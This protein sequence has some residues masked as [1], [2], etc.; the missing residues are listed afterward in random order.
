MVDHLLNGTGNNAPALLNTLRSLLFVEAKG[1]ALLLPDLMGEYVSAI[2]YGLGDDGRRD[3]EDMQAL[4]RLW[5]PQLLV[6][7]E[8]IYQL[9]FNFPDAT[10]PFRHVKL[11][12]GVPENS[13][14]NLVQ[15]CN[16]SQYSN[17]CI[18]KLEF[19]SS[20]LDADWSADESLIAVCSAKALFVVDVVL[21]S[22]LL[23]WEYP[24]RLQN[25][26]VRWSPSDTA[27]AM[28]DGQNMFVVFL[29]KARKEV[30]ATEIYENICR[31]YGVPAFEW[32][33]NQSIVYYDITTSDVT[34]AHSRH[35]QIDALKP[36]T[37]SLKHSAGPTRKAPIAPARPGFSERS[38]PCVTFS[39]GASMIVTQN[40]GYE[41][42]HTGHIR[43]H[44]G[45]IL[46]NL[47]TTPKKSCGG[48][49]GWHQA[50][51]S[52]T[53]DFLVI[54]QRGIVLIFDTSALLEPVSAETAIPTLE[55]LTF[56]SNHGRIVDG[57][58]SAS[59]WTD[60]QCCGFINGSK[61]LVCGSDISVRVFEMPELDR[62][63]TEPLEKTKKPLNPY[64][65]QLKQLTAHGQRLTCINPSRSQTKFLSTDKKI[66]NIWNSSA[67][68]DFEPA[69]IHTGMINALAWHPQGTHV[70]SVG[71]GNS[72][73]SDQ[74]M[75]WNASTQKQVLK[76]GNV[77]RGLIAV[78]GDG[79]LLAYSE[80]FGPKIIS[81]IEIQADGGM[82]ETILGT[83]RYCSNN[84]CGSGTCPFF[85]NG[86][87]SEVLFSPGV[88]YRRERDRHDKNAAPTPYF[89][90]ATFE[91][92][93]GNDINS[94]RESNL[95][96]RYRDARNSIV[97]YSLL[98]YMHGCMP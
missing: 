4:I 43:N 88:D 73:S 54:L 42:A 6:S 67:L 50:S 53:Q 31:A 64:P 40:D 56:T 65:R 97:I 92:M 71:P 34:S 25:A 68:L 52:A 22:V 90:P 72:S 79:R 66:M 30:I 58:E 62:T 28:F 19:G 37:L 89:D 39:A 5:M 55:P 11:G 87:H 27:I 86:E 83:A 15:Y 46:A 95:D 93:V 60:Y 33:S 74:V 7:P 1:K 36:S 9:A 84:H 41:N 57:V 20:L 94:E 48:C 61:H 96:V 3:V 47:N 59:Q 8:H 26:F 45:K 32:S 38:V 35:R 76:T 29:D 16:K 63:K 80:Q 85:G 51:F 75:A 98:V 23:S 91:K 82:R 24:Y 78:S 44:D 81:K 17:P 70:F 14:K 12:G 69:V 77:D 18:G 13:R 21:C 49:A 2:E 10:F